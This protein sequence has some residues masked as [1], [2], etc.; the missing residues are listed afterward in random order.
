MRGVFAGQANRKKS[1]DL[2]LHNS[3]DVDF[4]TLVNAWRIHFNASGRNF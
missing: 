1:V 2:C 4:V 3:I